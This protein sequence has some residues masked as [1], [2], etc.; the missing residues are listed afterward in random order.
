MKTILVTGGT[1]GIGKGVVMHFLKNNHRVIAVGSSSNKG[2]KLIS[3]AKMI[4]KE[5]NLYFVQADLSLVSENLRIAD[6]V[7][8]QFQSIDA[9]VLCAANLKPREAY[10]ETAEGF[11]FTFALYYLSRYIL[12]YALKDTLEKSNNPVIVNVSA[13][14]MKG[15]VN[16]NDLQFKNNYNGQ[17]VQFH[18][19]RLN[20]L[21]AVAFTQKDTIQKIKYVLFNPM[22]VR[23]SGARSMFQGQPL[24]QAM[25][26]LYYKLAGKS[27]DEI[28]IFI[29]EHIENSPQKHLSAYK[30]DKIIDLGMKTFDKTNAQKLCNM[31]EDLIRSYRL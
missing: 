29:V 18:G 25:M 4:Y 10:S 3:E 30:Q 22:A 7:H 24:M 28:V 26:K 21:L 6:E 31:T 23:T 19:S 2:S 5:N 9:L 1:D 16:W 14:G 8:K 20:D 17:K 15:K 27:V 12:S 11:E 13:P